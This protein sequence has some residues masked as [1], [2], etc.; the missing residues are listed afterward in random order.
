MIDKSI[1]GIKYRLSEENRTAEV[2]QKK[3]YE[4]DIIIP[5]TVV[6]QKVAYRVTSIGE[7]AFRGCSSLTSIVIPDSVTS[8]GSCAFDDCCSLTSIVIPDSVTSIGNCAFADCS[9]LTSI[10]IPDGVTSIG[11]CAFSS[12]SSLTSIVIPDSVTSIG[13]GAFSGCSS[14]TSV[15]VAEGNTVY[16]SREQCNAIIR[17]AT[18]TLISGCQNT[19][20]PDSVTS[21]GGGAFSGC[22]SLTSMVIPESVTSI[23]ES[24]F[25]DC[26][27]LTSIVIPDG[28]TSI[29]GWVFDGCS[30]LTSMVIPDGVTSIGDWTFSGCSSLTSIVIPDGVTSIGESAFEGC[31]SLKQEP[32]QEIEMGKVKYRLLMHNHLAMVF[33]YY[34]GS[35]TINIPSEINHEGVIYRV[36]SI[37]EYAFY[38]YFSL[39][40]IV[41]PD[42]VTSI[43]KE[44]FDECDS[45]TSIT[46]NGTKAQ[47]KEIKLGNDWKKNV[48]TNV[49]HCTDGDVEI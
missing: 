12:C 6:F 16:D 34:E 15:V 35:A 33:G 13:G 19:I 2:I 37:G 32:T 41:I 20:I 30:S 47:W 43:G 29:G 9:S 39:T 25:K 31:S 40:S 23:G 14:L 38:R 8:I 48:P 7:E 28:V 44:A 22:S 45:L 42:S 5:E 24:A 49:I 46:F 1:K 36:T 3:G 17:T 4:G 11:V 18:N 27:S 26:S 10:V 21:I